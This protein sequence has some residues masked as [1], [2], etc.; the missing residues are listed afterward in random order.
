MLSNSTFY[1]TPPALI[2]KMLAKVQGYPSNVLEPSA[3]KADL[4]EAFQVKF[5][6]HR[7]SSISAIEINP[8]LQA[9]LR[10]KGIKV[11]DTDFLAYT[12]PDK[13]DLIIANPPF[14]DGDKHL[15]KAIEIMYRGQI[16][17]L[18]NA[19][20]LR[21]P[22]TKTRKLL[23]RKLEE[24]GAKIEYIKNGFVDAERKTKVEVALVYIK[25]D[26]KVEDDLFADAK[27]K[28]KKATQTVKGKHEVSTGK[29][30]AELV[31]EYNQIIA[32]GT[33]TVVG[34]YRNYNKVGKYLSLNDT[35]DK[36]R[37][38]HSSDADL[39]G[40]MQNQINA[41]LVNVRTDF[42]RRTLDLP[43]VQK[44][45][46]SKKRDE[47]ESQ[48]KDRCNMDFTE[49]NIRQFILNLIGSYEQ[50][51][52]EA[53]LDLFD[54]FTVRHSYRDGCL[55]EKN[56][57]LFNGW[58]TNKAFKVGKRIVVPFWGEAF[59]RD[60]KYSWGKWDLDYGASSKLDDIDKVMSYFDG[61]AGYHSMSSA[62]TTAF[63]FGQTSGIESTYFTITVHKKGTAHLTFKNDDI[64]RR[65]SV[66]ACRGK[67][68]L[69]EDYGAKKF[70]L[71]SLDE[72]AV[73]ISFEDVASY[74][75]N[76][77]KPLFASLAGNA[78]AL[79]ELKRAA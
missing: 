20:T 73:V 3:G 57:H 41:M 18:L 15:L 26:R 79:I 1:P 42:W 25:I 48:V 24:L 27:D 70:N 67:N 63:R 39:T 54:M 58:K 10:G 32:I 52:T 76:V 53:V 29:T 69:P 4:I 55:E 21:N 71:L 30:I 22:H 31:A 23:A 5:D 2:A 14:D 47:F 60:A 6:R 37:Y 28:A 8:D 36:N 74:D 17:F 77:N 50:T 72:K 12:G 13:Y 38:S 65:F 43:E 49:S 40:K 61:M 68:W 9:T 34:F 56:I 59:F 35:N 19:E 11:V 16:V 78:G 33:E 44:R 7:S 75:K 51:L 64:L 45:L 62:I 66:V 46:T